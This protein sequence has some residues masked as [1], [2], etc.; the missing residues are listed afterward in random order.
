MAIP[1]RWKSDIWNIAYAFVQG[2]LIFTYLFSFFGSGIALHK[3]IFIGQ[4]SARLLS[5]SRHTERSNAMIAQK[6]KTIILSLA[7]Q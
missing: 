6:P 4:A 5:P 3:H 2:E 1:L 7:G